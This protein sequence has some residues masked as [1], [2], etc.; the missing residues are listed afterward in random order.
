[1]ATPSW[2]DRLL[3]LAAERHAQ[4]TLSRFLADA[5]RAD[6][7]QR[8]VLRQ[9]LARHA[10]SRFGREHRFDS[11]CGP[12]SF[13]SRLPIRTYG[14]F[15]PY[16]EDLR[17]GR[18]DSLLG[19]GQRVLMFALTSGTTRAPKYIPVTREF[20]DEY[21]R[22]WNAWGLR[23]LLDHPGSFLRH[24]VQVSSPMSDERTPAG[25][26]AGAITGLMAATQKRLVRKYYTAPLP[27]AYIPDAEAK[28]YAIM[29]LSVPRDV[30]FLIAANPATLLL[31]AR[32]ADLHR[33]RL[34]RDIHDGTLSHE[35]D[36]PLEV[37]AALHDRLAAEPQTA[38]RL[39][40]LVDRHGTLRPRDYWNLAFV[41]HWTGGT[42]GLYRARFPEWFG[43]VPVR[44]PG[45]LA[46]EGRMSIPIADNTPEGILDVTSHYFEFIPAEEY[47]SSQRRA[48]GIESVQV[49]GEYFLVL[50]T[51]SGLFRYDIGDRVRITGFHGR[52]PLV[53]FLSKGAHT[54]SLAGEKLTEHQVVAAMREVQSAGVVTADQFV[55]VPVWADPPRYRLLI[56]PRPD[57]QP[58]DANRL[59]MA[60]DSAL[61]AINFEYA[62]RRSSQRLGAVEARQTSPGELTLAD[63]EQRRR[64]AGRSEQFKHRYLL[65][66]VTPDDQSAV[67]EGLGH[68]SN[69]PL[70]APSE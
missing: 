50:S 41:A 24:I 4:R 59:G 5:E 30:A 21:R 57:G 46:S 16:I 7:T 15:E 58:I 62:G 13:G 44:D 8:R 56:E 52:A 9:K 22:G 42:M 25:I 1:M 61:A 47:E 51:S 28:Y 20:L 55:V 19:R 23:A 3:L 17:H 49:G 40:R 35:F 27:V 6:E 64:N 26:P 37:R 60:F 54:C 12:E 32:T 18:F 10:D 67:G 48:I 36:V 34:I 66:D 69:A 2:L 31:L 68:P 70:T 45:L 53:E 11:I 38:R 39:E 33:E 63:A 43:E 29:R 14:D 65:T